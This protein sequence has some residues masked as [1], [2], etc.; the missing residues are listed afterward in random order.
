MS[1]AHRFPL[2]RVGL[3]KPTVGILNAH[4]RR[5]APGLLLDQNAIGRRLDQ[6]KDLMNVK[7]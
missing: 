6:I 4:E 2:R 7:A 1:S 5:G 3:V